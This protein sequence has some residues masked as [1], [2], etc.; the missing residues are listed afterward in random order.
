MNLERYN[1]QTGIQDQKNTLDT[2][3]NND[4]TGLDQSQRTVDSLDRIKKEQTQA[5]PESID[6]QNAQAQAKKEAQSPD[7]NNES[8][9][10]RV[11]SREQKLSTSLAEYKN[12]N[13][14]S[15]SPEEEA[16]LRKKLPAY[17][18]MINARINYT[19]L[20]TNETNQEEN[21]AKITELQKLLTASESWQQYFNDQEKSKDTSTTNDT[22]PVAEATPEQNQPAVETIAPATNKT[23]I[24]E[25]ITEQSTNQPAVETIAPTSPNEAIPDSETPQ[26]NK[27]EGSHPTKEQIEAALATYGL[28]MEDVQKMLREGGSKNPEADQPQIEKNPFKNF[29]EE[30]LLSEISKNYEGLN[31]LLKQSAQIPE[32]EIV[33]YT[34]QINNI[35]QEIN[36]LLEELKNRE[37]NPN[38]ELVDQATELESQISDLENQPDSDEKETKLQ[39][40]REEHENLRSSIENNINNYILQTSPTISTLN[41]DLQIKDLNV[42]LQQKLLDMQT[43]AKDVISY[44]VDKISKNRINSLG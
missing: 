22:Q 2:S 23:T 43:K 29:S 5:T 21:Q 6:G 39:Q 32:G 10:S 44:R 18:K 33:V 24:K 1:Q 16:T 13:T 7:T 26:N 14:S 19:K 25:N 37:D 34:Q 41:Q 30:Q 9:I 11:K 42:N 38:Q 4:A 3:S 8:F 31:T 12:G 40:L 36:G 27:E 15:I 20:E 28:S 35:I 17:I